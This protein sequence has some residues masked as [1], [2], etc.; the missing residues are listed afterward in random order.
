MSDL[1]PGQ[2]IFTRG[3]V[4]LGALAARNQAAQS[5]A[6]QQQAAPA[7]SPAGG[8]GNGGGFPGAPAGGGVVVDVTE[9][10][11]QDEVLQRSM[12]TPV[13]VAFLAP[14]YP[15]VQ[16][17]ADELARFNAADGGSWVLARVDVQADP[18]LAAMFRVQSVPTV[19]AVVGGQPI[20]AFAG[21]VPAA[22]L[23][24]WLDAVLRA[25]GVE[26][27][28]PE[29]PRLEAADEALM[30]GDLDEAERAYRKI[31]SDSPKDAAAEAGLA[32]VVLA[33]RVVGVDPQ[34]AIA[35]ADAAP[36]D[37]AAQL[38]AA[39][40]EVLA[41]QAEQAYR[42]LVE[43][44]RRVYGDDREAVRQHLVSLFAVAG[45]DDPAVA[46]ARRALASALF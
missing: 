45:P 27:A 28:V 41:G 22:Q 36:D 33:K 19:Y 14:G 15:E 29:D 30:M 32:Q 7:A 18:R 26:V 12:T 21:P 2:S 43:L 24:Q 13:V 5:A 11:V 37:V 8:P 17:L 9:A 20:D 6:A 10:N 44:V 31:L 25:G 1:R 34:A 23:R 16:Q 40:V 35:A 38:T 3:A 42:R 46:A 39:D 4:D